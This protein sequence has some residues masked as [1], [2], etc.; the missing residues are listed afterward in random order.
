MPGAPTASCGHSPNTWRPS[1][2]ALQPA[3]WRRSSPPTPIESMISIARKVTGNVKRW[4][5]GRTALRWTAAGLLDAE[6]RF[7][8]VKGYREMV[9]LRR[10]LQNYHEALASK[11]PDNRPWIARNST[12]S[13]TSSHRRVWPDCRCVCVSDPRHGRGT[14]VL[15]EGDPFDRDNLRVGSSPTKPPPIQQP[16]P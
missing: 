1:T 4:R 8:R 15:R 16:S 5:N 3:C 13:G 10:A 14:L 11:A 12:D 6:K 7:R 2:L 9:M